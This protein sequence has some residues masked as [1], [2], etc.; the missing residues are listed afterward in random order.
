MG[1]NFLKHL[2]PRKIRFGDRK[3]KDVA[4]SNVVQDLKTK[5]KDPKKFL[6]GFWVVK[7]RGVPHDMVL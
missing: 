3:F 6:P 2:F 7:F 5:S 4:L 1:N